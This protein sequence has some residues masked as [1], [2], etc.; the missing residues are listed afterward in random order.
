LDSQH[1]HV[2]E[3]GDQGGILYEDPTETIVIHP[4]LVVTGGVVVQNLSGAVSDALAASAAAAALAP[5]QT[6]GDITT[7]T[8]ITGN[9][10]LN[11]IAVNSF[12]MHDMLTISGGPSDTFIF[13]VSGAFTWN[14]ATMTLSGVSPSRVLFNFPTTGSLINIFKPVGHAA[15]TFLAP[16]RSITLDKAT[17]DGAI[18][19]GGHACGDPANQITIHSAATLLCR[20]LSST[21]PT[22][23]R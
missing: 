10:G 16:L 6:F 1:G 8:T 5:T 17:L 12:N 2:G 13:N 20:L 7:A 4:D 18:I 3:G 9:G 14:G 19:G 23:T 11:V 22:P 21:S 15:G